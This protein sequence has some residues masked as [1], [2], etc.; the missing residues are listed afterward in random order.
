MFRVTSL[1]VT[2]SSIYR[3]E[4]I[5][6]TLG[7]LLHKFVAEHE[8]NT[9][10]K[11]LLANGLFIHKDAVIEKNFTKSAQEIYDNEIKIVDFT[12]AGDAAVNFINQ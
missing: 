1:T 4:K 8:N 11:V 10:I 2:S 3:E 12:A 6:N 9:A 5:H 7:Q